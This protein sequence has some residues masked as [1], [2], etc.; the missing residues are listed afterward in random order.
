MPLADGDLVDGQS[1]R[2]FSLACRSAFRGDAVWMSLIDIP[3]DLEML[4]DIL[5]GHVPRQFQGIA[6]EGMGVAPPRFGEADLH[7]TYELAIVTL[8]T[9]NLHEDM[10]LLAADGKAVEQTMFPAV[11]RDVLR[12]T[13][14]TA[15]C[16]TI[17]RDRDHH[18]PLEEV[19]AH[20]TVATNAK[21]M[22]Q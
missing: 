12:P 13:G 18:F 10:G 3:T 21:R 1:C 22:I 19:G 15:E 6:L 5:D 9:R 20:I 17:L 14:G 7:L 8:H 16:V 11:G 2:C 4:G